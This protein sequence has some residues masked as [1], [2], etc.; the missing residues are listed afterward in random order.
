MTT[1]GR[2]S[3]ARL[4]VLGP[5]GV[6]VPIRGRNDPLAPAWAQLG[7]QSEADY[8]LLANAAD[9]DCCGRPLPPFDRWR[10]QPPLTPPPGGFTNRWRQ[11]QAERD[12]AEGETDICV[13]GTCKRVLDLGQW[14]T[15]QTSAEVLQ[16]RLF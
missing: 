4:R 5:K 13:C 7:Y 3:S 16:G 9:C 15:R 14:P 8:N 11:A 2:R 10:V 1:P 6:V 12:H